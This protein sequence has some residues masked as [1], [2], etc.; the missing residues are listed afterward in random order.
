MI[1]VLACVCVVCA[2]VPLVLT[3]ANLGFFRR[4][5]LIAESQDAHVAVLIPARDE[6]RNLP[7]L[8]AT[9]SEQ[10]GWRGEVVVC[11]DHSTDAT[12]RLA[13][14]ANARVVEA[15]ALPPGWVGKQ[16]ACWVLANETEAPILCWVDAD[17]RLAPDAIRAAADYLRRSG[18]AC[19]SGF[20]REVT[21]TALEK[22]VVPLIHFILLGFLP[23]PAMKWTTM[24]A[25]A[26]GCGQWM[27]AERDA[28]FAVGGHAG[29]RGSRHDGI[30][31][32]R[33]FRDRGYRT[34]VFDATDLAW[35]RM[36]VGAAAMWAGMV[37]NATEGMASPGAI[38]PFSVLLLFGQVVPF[39]LIGVSKWFGVAA[40]MAMV[41][42]GVCAVRFRQSW[43]GVLLHPVSVVL[44]LVAQW[45]ALVMEMIG[46]RV[47][48]RGRE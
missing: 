36:Y 14:D 19:V 23:F 37:K 45:Q 15:P 7:E 40:G 41:A 47:A 35:C 8:L 6:E 18:A 34:D 39:A 32:P 10:V 1:V 11:D 3:L 44:L 20:P 26:A 48:W 25:F 24:P 28:Y 30:T 17:V 9:V 22:M 2:A 31:L 33:L 27:L 13:G 38:L 4:P 43:L 21:G 29:I 42:R 5:V 16:H 46:K 12:A